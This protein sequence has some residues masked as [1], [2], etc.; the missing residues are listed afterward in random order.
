MGP[1]FN[2]ALINVGLSA[3]ATDNC[4]G[5]GA[6]QVFVFS[7]E[8]DGP[9]PHSPDATDIGIGTLKLRRER[10]GSSDGRVYLVVVKVTD[11]YGNTTASCSTVGVPL[12][13]SSAHVSSVNAQA[14][15]AASFCSVNNG[16]AP[17]GYLPVGP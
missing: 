8:D 7:D 15:A 2:H 5:L 9:A 4:P 1:A 6:F 13:S 14:A 12:S 3:N 11:A 16:A 10:D 17:A